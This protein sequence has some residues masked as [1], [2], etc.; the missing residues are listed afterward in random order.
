VFA[1]ARVCVPRACVRALA[2]KCWC[3]CLYTYTY[4][5]RKAPSPPSTH[6]RGWGQ[7]ST[8]MWYGESAAQS[9]EKKGGIGEEE[10]EG[11]GD[12]KR[13]D[14]GDEGASA[15]QQEKEREE[16]KELKDRD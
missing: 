1:L 11:I 12:L 10:R 16:K 4:K 13:R 3:M 14:G 15:R 9:G 5:D 6:R 2:R 8:G 7:K